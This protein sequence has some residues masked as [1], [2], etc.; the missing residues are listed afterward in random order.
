MP[1]CFHHCTDAKGHTGTSGGGD[2]AAWHREPRQMI[3]SG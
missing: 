3:V 1:L 2:N